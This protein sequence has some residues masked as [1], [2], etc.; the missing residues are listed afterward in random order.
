M[1][2][3]FDPRT[4]KNPH[5]DEMN[6]LQTLHPPDK[7]YGF[8]KIE[9]PKTPFEYASGTDEDE[10]D[11][12]SREVGSQDQDTASDIKSSKSKS[13]ADNLDANLLAAK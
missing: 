9:E 6:N 8:M 5:F 4:H 10:L 1:F 11:D 3:N 7:D 12:D 13:S 2:L